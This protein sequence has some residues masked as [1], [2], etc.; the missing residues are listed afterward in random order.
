MVARHE[1]HFECIGEQFSK[2]FFSVFDGD[3]KAET[4]KIDGVA[5]PYSSYILEKTFETTYAIPKKRG[6]RF[7]RVAEVFLTRLSLFLTIVIRPHGQH[8]QQV[9]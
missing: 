7:K 8:I 9:K 1:H 2:S 5:S 3:F 6:E 4:V